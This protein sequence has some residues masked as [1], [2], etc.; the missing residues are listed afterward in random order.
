M[1]RRE[2]LTEPQ[3]LAFTEPVTDAWLRQT[4]FAATA[5]NFPKLIERLNQIRAIGIEPERAH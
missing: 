1:P 2:L 5:G 3:R 4:A